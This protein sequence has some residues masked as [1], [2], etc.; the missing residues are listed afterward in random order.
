MWVLGV[1][2]LSSIEVLIG[3]LSGPVPIE[4]NK[5][6]P[7]VCYVTIQGSSSRLNSEIARK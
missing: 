6:I 7:I 2:A 3:L 5:V 1:R 4:L